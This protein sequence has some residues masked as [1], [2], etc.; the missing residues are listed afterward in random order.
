MDIAV[1]SFIVSNILLFF[2]NYSAK[3]ALPKIQLLNLITT[4]TLCFIT[5]G[6]GDYK[7]VKINL[8]ITNFFISVLLLI[9]TFLK[10]NILQDIIGTNFLLKGDSW[11]LL[12]RRWSVFFLLLSISNEFVWRF[13]S[14]N[15]WVNFKVFG[16]IVF[17]VTLTLLQIPFIRRNID[18]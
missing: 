10:K 13:T 8:T 14:D 6:T 9:S 16:I 5:L 12:S 2:V 1:S 11:I 17:T 4:C 18:F 3:K 7:Y 15:F